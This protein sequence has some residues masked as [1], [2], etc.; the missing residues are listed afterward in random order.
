MNRK[1][2]LICGAGSIG[3]YLGVKLSS[4][5]HYVDLF[6]R[7]KLRQT[8]DE[9]TINKE[10]FPVPKKLFIIPKNQEY[11]FVFLTTKLY[12]LTHMVKH[13]KKSGIKGNKFVG[14]QNGLVDTTKYSRLL[15]KR[16]IPVVV[17]SG[18]NL[19]K[20]E[21]VVNK[22]AVGWKTEYSTDGK[23]V[24][25]FLLRTGIPCTSDKKFDSL[26]AE[27]AIVNSCLNALSAIEKKSFRDLFRNKKTRQ[28]IESLFY[29]S[30][31]ILEKE[32]ELESMEKLKNKMFKH[33]SN[34]D[35]FSSTYQDIA[36]GRQNEASF[37]NGYLIQLG[38]GN[39]CPIEQNKRIMEEISRIK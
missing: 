26:R 35:H 23:E 12:D 11:D 6:G 13:I 2:V 32:Y 19:K 28:R 14:I 38:K 9:I 3:V 31:R 37:F 1:R 17:F 34:L 7:R 20:N 25:K 39:R 22:T 4:N 30:Y 36:S 33:W 16:I 5:G 27:K 15:K 29:E 18:F 24:S 10:K 8:E 21:I